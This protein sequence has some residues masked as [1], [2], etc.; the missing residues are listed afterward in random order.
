MSEYKPVGCG[1][2]DELEIL[3]MRRQHVV[4]DYRDGHGL[5]LQVEGRIDD[6]FSREGEEFLRL[7]DGPQLR[8]DQLIRVNGRAA[9]SCE[10]G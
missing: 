3:A 6:V 7:E 10:I 4:I 2:Y 5:E 1:F 8:L 9:D